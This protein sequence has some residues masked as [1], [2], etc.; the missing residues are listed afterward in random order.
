MHQHLERGTSQV[1]LGKRVQKR[2]QTLKVTQLG[3]AQAG[4]VTPQ[5]ISLIEQDKATASLTLL[6]KL[7][8]ELGVSTD[9]LISG[10]EGIITDTIAAIKA[11]KS[12]KLKAKRILI[13]LV[14]EFRNTDISEEPE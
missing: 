8:E 12:L 2:R 7:A 5:H 3:L 4:G 10:K 14:E 9:Y 13:A 11:D 1:S 6:A